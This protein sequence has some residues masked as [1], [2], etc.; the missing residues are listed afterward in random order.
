MKRFG[1]GIVAGLG[2]T[3]GAL[4]AV[5]FAVAVLAPQHMPAPAISHLVQ[6]D[7]KLRFIREHPE[8]NPRVVAVGSSVAFRQ[9]D[10]KTMDALGVPG[11]F[12]NGATVYLKVHQTRELVKFYMEHFP[13]VKT[14]VL[15]TGIP[16]FEE[17]RE[18]PST[19]FDRRQAARYAFDR[20]P[21]LYFYLRHFSIQRYVQ[22]GLSLPER[23]RPLTGDLYMDGYGSGPVELPPDVELGLRY[24]AI[25]MDPT[26]LESLVALSKET[27]AR[28]IDLLIVFTPINPEYRQKYPE[29]A[30]VLCR[31]AKNTM[32]Q[33]AG[34]R[35][36][37]LP[38]QDSPRFAASDFYDAFHVEWPAVPALTALI[39]A[40]LGTPHPQPAFV[41]K[42]PASSGVL[43]SRLRNRTDEV[44]SVAVAETPC[45][46]FQAYSRKRL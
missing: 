41:A 34:D 17:C 16:D 27:T 40:E 46:A 13:R 30:T 7:E 18:E 25:R 26:C 8:L 3:C 42:A 39:A 4:I 12:F 1:I 14:V 36:T 28:G 11:E 44:Q 22:T 10:G 15:L 20:W 21:N 6:M 38:L 32:A 45:N 19:V 9:L 33:T 37:V 43:E 23:R 31:I 2:A 35:T 24:G 5:F 29:S